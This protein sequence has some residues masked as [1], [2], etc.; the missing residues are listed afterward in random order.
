[1]STTQLNDSLSNIISTKCEVVPLDIT[2]AGFSFM[3]IFLLSNFVVGLPANA[4]VIWLICHGTREQLASELCLLSL[5]VCE[6][7]YHL[8]LPAQ[9]YCMYSFED[10]SDGLAKLLIIQGLLVWVGRPI[11]QSSICVE[12]YTAVVHPL[13]FIR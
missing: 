8:G 2:E 7:L 13:I 10:A 12:H 9:L 5:A 1:M 4:W 6:M 11:F 3:V